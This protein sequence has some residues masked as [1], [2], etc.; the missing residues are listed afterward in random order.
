LLELILSQRNDWNFSASF[1]YNLIADQPL[2]PKVDLMICRY[3]R[4]ESMCEVVP[5]LIIDSPKL[6][7]YLRRL[8]L[9]HIKNGGDFPLEA[10]LD[11]LLQC[12]DT[13]SWKYMETFLVFLDN[14]RSDL[15]S[16]PVFRQAL[17][18]SPGAE[19]LRLKPNKVI[20]KFIPV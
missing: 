4:W 14:I 3:M 8:E 13:N 12:E 7:K 6:Q 18:V 20:E 15:V 16:N 1:Y 10:A 5:W 2:P 11:V 19:E 9:I 17:Q